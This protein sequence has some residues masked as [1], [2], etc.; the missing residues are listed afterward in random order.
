MEAIL[1]GFHTIGMYIL[2][3]ASGKLKKNSEGNWE[4]EPEETESEEEEGEKMDVP[5]TSTAAA[6]ASETINLVLS[7]V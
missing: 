1:C 3:V 6:T 5:T 4:F 7:F 2:Q